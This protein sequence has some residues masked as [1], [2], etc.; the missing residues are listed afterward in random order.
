MAWNDVQLFPFSFRIT[1]A[2]DEYKGEHINDW[3]APQIKNGLV[4]VQKIMT[5]NYQPFGLRG[6]NLSDDSSPGGQSRQHRLTNCQ[7]LEG[8]SQQGIP[9]AVWM[10]RHPR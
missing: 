6:F 4:E 7:H 9:E 5:Q 1:H 10:K 3:E 2:F 8:R